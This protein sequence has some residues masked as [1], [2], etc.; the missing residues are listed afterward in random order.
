LTEA[1][2]GRVK[3]L[4][5][6][7][8]ALKL[9]PDF[10]NC[11]TCGERMLVKEL[12]GHLSTHPMHCDLCDKWVSPRSFYGHILEHQRVQGDFLS[13]MFKEAEKGKRHS[14]ERKVY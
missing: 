12:P 14:L 13:T 5:G 4:Y 1:M 2:S 3:G 6:K 10:D 8:Y 9:T 7:L 11:P